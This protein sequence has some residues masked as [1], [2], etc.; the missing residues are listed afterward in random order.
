MSEAEVISGL[1]HGSG[2]PSTQVNSNHHTT[3][4]AD[5]EGNNKPDGNSDSLKRIVKDSTDK[6]QQKKFDSTIESGIKPYELLL[7]NSS[8]NSP[9]LDPISSLEEITNGHRG[10]SISNRRIGDRCHESDEELL[11]IQAIEEDVNRTQSISA[12]EIRLTHGA[13]LNNNDQVTTPKSDANNIKLN[14]PSTTTA[15]IAGRSRK[16][17]TIP[18]GIAVAW[19]RNCTNTT[20]TNCATNSTSTLTS[21]MSSNNVEKAKKL[22]KSPKTSPL[23]H[24]TL[25]PADIISETSSNKKDPKKKEKGLKATSTNINMSDAKLGR[26]INLNNKS[27]TSDSALNLKSSVCEKRHEKEKYYEKVKSNNISNSTSSSFTPV[28]PV[29]SKASCGN[30]NSSINERF[31][32]NDGDGGFKSLNNNN[33]TLSLY[34]D[35]WPSSQPLVPQGKHSVFIF[36]FLFLNFFGPKSLCHLFYS[37]SALHC[38]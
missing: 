36:P 37:F 14:N 10:S 15:K 35:S 30:S 38:I 34:R 6:I 2:S 12:N 24:N 11:D 23:L 31:N 27:V 9:V 17:S 26:T 25:P 20:T 29:S 28:T 33:N 22:V 8:I 4:E 5:G 21:T 18:V 19:Q 13:S 32:N 3:D 1:A 7:E 16:V